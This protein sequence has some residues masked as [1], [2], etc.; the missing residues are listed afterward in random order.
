MKHL[1]PLATTRRIWRRTSPMIVWVTV[2]GILTPA[3]G[4]SNADGHIYGR[5]DA[6]PAGASL[7]ATNLD[8]GL[9]RETR[10]DATGG[11]RFSSLPVG[12]YIVALKRGG[13]PDEIS[14]MVNVAVGT[15]SLA[16]FAVPSRVE[17]DKIVL[18]TVTVSKGAISPIDVQSTESATV[19]RAETIA[20]LPVERKLSAVAL[21]AP[22]TAQGVAEFGDLVSFGGS[23]VAEN[24]YF[25]NG[26]NLTSF[27]DGLSYATVPFEFYDNFQVKTGGYSSEFGRSTGGVQNSTTKRG[28]NTWEGGVNA[29]WSPEAL[30]AH[31]TNRPAN[32]SWSFDT[33]AHVGGPLI[34]N[35]L[36]VYGLYNVRRTFFE[37]ATTFG[38][39][40][41]TSKDPF[42][43]AKLDWNISDRHS[44]ELTAFSDQ[45]ANAVESFKYDYPART[46]LA[47]RGVTNQLRGG[48]T[49]I[50]RYTGVLTDA[51]TLSLL[52]G[53]GD[54]RFT[55]R[56]A[57][58]ASPYILD[59]RSG[60]PVQLG[61][62]TSF[63]PGVSEDRR[64]ASRIDGEYALG[65]HRFRFGFDREDTN[66]YN[67]TQSSGGVF[68]RYSVTTSA[69]QKLPNGALVPLA[70]T[71]IADKNIFRS[72]GN[73]R[74]LNDALYAE[75]SWRLMDDRLLLNLGVRSDGFDNR[76][77]NGQTFLKLKNEIGPRVGAAFDV[78]KD[79]R[80]KLFVNYGRYFLPIPAG[81][82]SIL[83]GSL[84][85]YNEYY[86]LNGLTPDSLPQLGPQLGGRRVILDGTVRDSREIVDRHLKPMY[87][88]EY[89]LG[90]QRALNPQWT[91]GLRGI[92]RDLRDSQEDEAID[93]TLNDYA[94]TNGLENFYASGNDYWVLANPGRPL[95]VTIDFG[96]GKGPRDVT[97][98]PAQLKYPKARRI[99]W[100][101]ELFFERIS[102]GKWFLQGSYTLSHSYGNTEGWTRSDDGSAGI[103]S[104]AFDHPGLMDGA[105]GDL[106]NDHRHKLKLFGS[107]AFT[108]SLQFG[109]NVQITSGMPISAF[110]YHPTDAFANSYGAASHYAGRVLAPRGSGGRTPWITSWNLSLRYQPAWF[111]ARTTFGVDVFNVLNLQ[112]PTQVNQRAD[113]DSTGK[114]DPDYKA[115]YQYQ[116][117][118]SV[119]FRAD[120][121]F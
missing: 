8:T 42:W 10:P 98:T 91:V 96:D 104:S 105:F 61:Q 34:K 58:D 109:T 64:H 113:L 119:R 51:L 73:F 103:I 93:E 45:G 71:Q 40:R 97:F 41:A 29:F 85:F 23:S 108:R 106:P 107:Y 101:A 78:A 26:F 24:V 83:A 114:P 87:Q 19:F 48:K 89:I 27:R 36:F 35:K 37:S 95:T 84:L 57:G 121:K 22:G 69:N 31:P 63:R 4:Q 100:A 56:G 116:S 39:M 47:S 92:Y 18:Q 12:R 7:S 82:N 66:L 60:S 65:A 2:V 46:I 70:G 49:Y 75:D 30:N 55:N 77:V 74:T 88:D 17:K 52:A 120:V 76:N 72:G 15:G 16:R 68:W 79:G 21:L 13:R 33:N 14:E 94:R 59:Y 118:R 43:G 110:G 32:Q 5:V 20:Q 86:V 6:A 50:A 9:H 1:Q 67:F 28:G 54:T 102:D 117:P 44:V 99:Y 80:S 3:R 25:V 11:F 112:H 81:T 90:Y 53:R 38:M 62:A 115:P 111:G